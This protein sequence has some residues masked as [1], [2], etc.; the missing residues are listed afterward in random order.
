MLIATD[1]QCLEILSLKGGCTCLSESTLVKMP[2]CWKSHV[3]A[4]YG[5]SEIYTRLNSHNV[6]TTSEEPGPEAIKLFM[7]NSTEHETYLSW[8]EMS[9]GM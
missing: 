6:A 7:L 1:L 8:S 2:H 5:I 9:H 4:H 3:T